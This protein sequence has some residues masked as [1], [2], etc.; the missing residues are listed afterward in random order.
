MACHGV[1]GGG[2]GGG[3]GGGVYGQP[4][5]ID[6]LTFAGEWISG[7]TCMYLANISCGELQH[8]QSKFIPSSLI[9]SVKAMRSDNLRRLVKCNLDS[10]LI[11]AAGEVPC[12]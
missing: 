1:V 7:A 10:S 8:S 4:W 11:V 6:V 9:K 5:S 3:G 12:G 2:G